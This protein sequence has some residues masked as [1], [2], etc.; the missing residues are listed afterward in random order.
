MQELT[1]PDDP[2]GLDEL[3]G[4]NAG[5]NERDSRL[6]WR[7]LRACARARANPAAT[8]STRPAEKSRRLMRSPLW[9]RT[10]GRKYPATLRP[11]SGCMQDGQRCLRNWMRP[12]RFRFNGLWLSERPESAQRPKRSHRSGSSANHP[13]ETSHRPL[14]NGRSL[15]ITCRRLRPK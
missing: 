15:G 12:A 10:D 14:V 11:S 5:M 3:I 4:G 1:Y 2:S 13:T 7:R 8:T 6:R 9:R